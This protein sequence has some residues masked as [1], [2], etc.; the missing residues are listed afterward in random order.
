MTAATDIAD[1]ADIERLVRAFYADAMA[2]PMIGYLFTDVAQ[3]DLEVHVPV[4]TD[5]WETVLLGS[6]AYRGGAFA[7]H[8]R[9]DA[10]SP[11]RDGHF[12]RWVALWAQTVDAHFAGPV[13]ET[14]KAHAQR[15]ARAF[16]RRLQGLSEEP[17]EPGLLRVIPPGPAPR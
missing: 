7:P 6:G 15:V 1:R 14:A 16:S 11:L 4:I 17:A 10:R 12:R 2:D 8:A 13:A 3:L 5:F 9:L